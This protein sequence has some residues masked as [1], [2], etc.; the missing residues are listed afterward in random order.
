M[1]FGAMLI[2][3][4]CQAQLQDTRSPGLS[5]HFKTVSGPHRADPWNRVQAG[6]GLGIACLAPPTKLLTLA[7]RVRVCLLRAAA[8]PAAT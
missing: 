8:G 1:G 2:R 6:S 3:A 5:C 7:E 4:E